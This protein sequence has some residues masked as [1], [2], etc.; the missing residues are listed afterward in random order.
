MH[1]AKLLPQKI[2]CT[3]TLVVACMISAHSL[4][5]SDPAKDK[6]HLQEKKPDEKQLDTTA[7]GG[8]QIL[9]DTMG[10]DFTPYVGQL[11]S[12]IYP[13]WVRNIPDVAREP[14]LK[15]GT[16]IFEFSI[17]K[18]GRVAGL[19]L[20]QSSG[21]KSMDLAPQMAIISVAPLPQL[22]VA[23]RGDYLQIRCRFIY[24]PG[25]HAQANPSP[26]GQKK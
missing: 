2:A 4:P 18:D 21:D 15:Q 12:R 14:M 26:G 5:Q 19:K 3:L 20:T 11:R 22:P 23:F 17:F 13:A 16:A 10:V 25:P 8:F 6:A 7:Q 1:I 9:S 24:N